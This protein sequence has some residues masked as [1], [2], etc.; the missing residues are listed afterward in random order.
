MNHRTE[1]LIES[2]FANML[3]DVER[4]EL[5]STLAADPAAAAEFA[6]QQSL[7]R[8]ISKRSLTQGI[9]NDQWREAAKPPFRNISMYKKVLAAAAAIA[10]LIVAYVFIPDPDAGS[11]Q[12]LLAQSIEH[13][14]NKMKFK[15][16][17]EGAE[18][19]SPDVLDA[20]AAYDQKDYLKA[21]QKLTDVVN[22]NTAR[23]DYRFYL[24]MSFLGQKKYAETINALLAVAQDK[25]S[26]YST[27]SLYFLGLAYAGINDVEQAQKHLQAYIDAADG[28]TYKKQAI[29]L[30]KRLK[31]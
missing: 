2:Y 11:T 31:Q 25:S 23:M 21:S 14:P 20:F 28:V 24:G 29:R 12:E 5:K 4:E 15:N 27:P 19:V 1:Q 17:G 16:L 13:F 10:L 22:A 3:T 26:A 9:K 6:W 7:A 30:L 18:T 8:Q